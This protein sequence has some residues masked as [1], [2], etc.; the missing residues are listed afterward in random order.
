[1]VTRPEAQRPGSASSPV[2]FYGYLRDLTARYLAETTLHRLADEQAALRRVATLVARE[3]SPSEVFAAVVEEVGQVL[4]V[5]SVHLLRH[6]DDTMVVVG[7]WGS[8]VA[9]LGTRGF[10]GGDAGARVSAPIVVQGRP[11][12]V[13]IASSRS[14]EPLPP[15]TEA[16]IGEF[17]EL[18][19]TA[20]SNVQARSDLAAS[21][22]RLVAAADAERRGVVRDLHDGT[23]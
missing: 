10:A 20:I 1:V 9:P 4:S 15:D 7:A 2:I 16:R 11:W 3:R 5:E 18:V 6:E 14:P 17:T 22:A 21:R 19:A 13:M 23:Q 8:D 12:G